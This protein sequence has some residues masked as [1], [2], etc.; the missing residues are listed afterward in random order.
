MLCKYPRMPL[1]I[2]EAFLLGIP[3]SDEKESILDPKLQSTMIFGSPPPK[4][5]PRLNLKPTKIYRLELWSFP[6]FQPKSTSKFS[7]PK[8]ISKFHTRHPY[9]MGS[10][11]NYK[12]GEITPISRVITTDTPWE[13]HWEGPDVTPFMTGFCC[14]HLVG[15]GCFQQ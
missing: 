5:F 12:W 6:S 10:K 4:P 13:G 1:W 7:Y 8:S 2:N 15:Y 3:G 11:T 14:A 9:K